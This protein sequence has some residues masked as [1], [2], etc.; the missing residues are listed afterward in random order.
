MRGPEN[1]I[2]LDTEV[3]S[4]QPHDVSLFSSMSLCSQMQQHIVN[5]VGDQ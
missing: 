1:D 3:A 5:P 2:W 4:L